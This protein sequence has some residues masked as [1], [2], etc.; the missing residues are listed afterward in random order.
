MKEYPKQQYVYT[1]M[2]GAKDKIK[3]GNSS[4]RSRKIIQFENLS[5]TEQEK[6]I[7]KYYKQLGLDKKVLRSMQKTRTM[8][9]LYF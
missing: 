8:E 6:I 7:T 1:V 3:N 9:Y 2:L 5:E 4:R